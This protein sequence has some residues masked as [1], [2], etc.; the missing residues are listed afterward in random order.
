MTEYLAMTNKRLLNG[1]RTTVTHGSADGKTTYC[2]REIDR[3]YVTFPALE[4]SR[5]SCSGCIAAKLKGLKDHGED[6]TTT[7]DCP[8]SE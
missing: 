5:L 8:V 2:G 4:R 7:G 1:H 6:N 3:W